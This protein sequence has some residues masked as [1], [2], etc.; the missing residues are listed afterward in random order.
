MTSSPSPRFLAEI[1]ESPCRC[2][3]VLLVIF[4][5][6]AAVYEDGHKLR[7]LQE[8]INRKCAG[9]HDRKDQDCIDKIRSGGPAEQKCSLET[10]H[11]TVLISG[12]SRRGPQASLVQSWTGRKPGSRSSGWSRSRR[13]GC[14]KPK[15]AYR[16]ESDASSRGVVGV[17]E[18]SSKLW[19]QEDQ[20][21]CVSSSERWRCRSYYVV[22]VVMAGLRLPQR[23]NAL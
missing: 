10:G 4:R 17:P 22:T 9:A 12:E 7:R 2:G 19:S 20:S 16:R 23:V 3:L 6:Q 14:G 11:P 21:G 5:S 18:R 1:N 15:H 13:H 8:Y